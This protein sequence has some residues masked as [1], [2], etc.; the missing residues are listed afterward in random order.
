MTSSSPDAGSGAPVAG[1]NTSS[2]GLQ[3]C[4]DYFSG[5]TASLDQQC[6]QSGGTTAARCDHTNAVGGC[7]LTTTVAGAQVQT[8]YWYYYDT[9]SDIMA[10]CAEANAPF[11]SP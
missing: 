1:C 4:T 5:S 3:T 9:P 10:A 2:S 11:V 7:L 8:I 6:A